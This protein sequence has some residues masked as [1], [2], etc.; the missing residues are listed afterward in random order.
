MGLPNAIT[1]VRIFM[2][3]VFVALAYAHSD[4]AAVASFLVFTVASLSDMLD[5]YLARRYQVVSRLGTFLDPLADKLLVGAA[6]YVLVDTR[7]F[8]LWAALIVAVRELAIQWLRVR[9]NRSGGELPA[10]PAAKAKTFTQLSMIGWWLLPWSDQNLGHWVLL[11]L[12]L[13]TTLWSGVEYFVRAA[14]GL[15]E[16]EDN[17]PVGE[18]R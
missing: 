11:S 7:A 16:A 18:R 12:A 8:P 2:V 4:A 6:L 10:S 17:T 15:R 5:G 1:V 3:P 14:Q 13:V 9:I